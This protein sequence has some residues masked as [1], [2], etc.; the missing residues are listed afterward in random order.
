MT[1]RGYVYLLNHLYRPTSTLPLATVQA[2]L[3]HYLAH[4]QPTPTSLAGTL[5][6]SPLFRPFAHAKLAALCAALRHALRIRVG[7]LRAESRGVFVRGVGARTTE[8]VGWVLEGLRGGHPVMRLVCCGGLLLGMEDL[9]GVLHVREGKMR[10]EVEEEIVLALAEVIDTYSRKESSADWEK[11]FRSEGQDSEDP[12]SLTLLISSEFVPLVSVPRLRTLPLPLLAD[13]IASTIESTFQQGTFLS[14]VSSSIST[15][16]DGKLVL[17]PNSLFAHNIRAITASQYLS[18]MGPLSRFCALVISVLAESRPL[19]GWPVMAQAMWRMESIAQKA[20]VDWIVCPLAAVTDENDI[21][22]ESREL[23]TAV[24]TIL[25]TELFMTIMITQSVLST[26][27]YVPHPTTRLST[28]PEPS[29]ESGDLSPFSLSATALSTLSHLSFVIQQFGGV[30]STSEGGF[31]ELKRV[32]YMALD[33]LSASPVE[34]EHF[35]LDLSDTFKGAEA[36]PPAKKAYALACIEQLVPVLS[37]ERIKA[38]VFPLCLPHLFDPSHRETYESA[39]SVMLAVFASHAQKAGERGRRGRSAAGS[40]VRSGA[41]SASAFAEEVVPFYVQC[42]I[43]NS[44]EGKMSTT[45]LCLAYA[46]VVRSASAFGAQRQDGDAVA[47]L[48]VDT[49]LDAIYQTASHSRSPDANADAPAPAP[50][51]AAKHLHRLHLALVTTVPC[52]SLAL[53]PRV[54]RE[55]K[56]FIMH[57]SSPVDRSPPSTSASASAPEQRR[58]ELV[59]RLF[60]ELSENT[61]DAEKA[62][63]MRWWYENREVLVGTSGPNLSVSGLGD[64]GSEKGSAPAP[65]RDD[66]VAKL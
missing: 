32:F 29:D 35:V 24:W 9:D 42:L 26:V 41:E 11:D 20:E 66:L 13:L 48:C 31:A 10:K 14:G 18:S 50:G 51:A 37:D 45:Q 36:V 33:V 57:S 53:L 4:L 16:K 44:G 3:A 47:W 60:S 28:A 7:L 62:F 63:G 40:A 21:A 49:L 1:D 19:R 43:D 38:D 61:G 8:W 39:H 46:A 22:P 65:E 56:D 55:I 34:S 15:D 12:L 23:T 5:V 2:S 64:R 27:V 30:T 17:A 54:L 59:R 58:T 52:L 6:G 25:K